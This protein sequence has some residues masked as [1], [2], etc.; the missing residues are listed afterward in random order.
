M[1]LRALVSPA[2]AARVPAPRLFHAAPAGGARPVPSPLDGP[3]TGKARGDGA[4]ACRQNRST[5]LAV[6]SSRP[7][8]NKLVPNVAFRALAA[9]PVRVT[10]MPL[11][12]T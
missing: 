6:P 2:S 4:R 12:R 10:T 1:A 8:V 11:I 5:V 9:A 7:G 3:V